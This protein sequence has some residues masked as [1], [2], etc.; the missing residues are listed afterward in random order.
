L[1]M[2]MNIPVAQD[3][4]IQFLPTVAKA[5]DYVLLRSEIDTIMA[6]SACPQDILPINGGKPV[7]CHFQIL[8]SSDA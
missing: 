1:N 7:E 6:F 2:W 8:K 4:S 5:G 3:G